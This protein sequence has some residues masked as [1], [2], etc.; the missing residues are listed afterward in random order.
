MTEQPASL[1]LR[2]D[3]TESIPVYQED[4]MTFLAGQGEPVVP[5]GLTEYFRTAGRDRFGSERR[6]KDF[7]GTGGP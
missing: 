5:G 6:G 3:G 4:S 7:H 1:G 2:M